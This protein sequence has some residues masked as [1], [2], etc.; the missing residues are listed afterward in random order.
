MLATMENFAHNVKVS[1]LNQE[2]SLEELSA[3]TGLSLLHLCRIEKGVNK[4]SLYSA[5]QISNAL[6]EDIGSLCRNWYELSNKHPYL[7][8]KRRKVYAN[9]Q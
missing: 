5:I 1:R 9:E 8:G 7:V 6:D 3:K 4:P 2:L